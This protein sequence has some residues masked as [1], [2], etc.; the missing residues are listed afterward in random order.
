MNRAKFYDHIR[1]KVH[2]GKLSTSQVEG[3]EKILDYWEQQ[4]PHWT[5]EWL[6]YGLAT[7][8]HETRGRMYPC[9]EDDNKAGTYLKKKKYYPWYG[10]GLIQITWESNYLKYGITNPDDA[11]KWDKAL[12]IMFDG[13][14]NGKFTGKKLSGYD[15]DGVF[16]PK[17]ARAIINGNDDDDLIA[18]YYYHYLDAL[19]QAREAPRKPVEKVPATPVPEPKENWLLALLKWIFK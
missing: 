6:A 7:V 9:E 12:F 17:A 19:K 5:L 8:F 2:A 13:M 3:Y 14:E 1:T 10:R 11:L 18:G 4:Y 15:K 16:R